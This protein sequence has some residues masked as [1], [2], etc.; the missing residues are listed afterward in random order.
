MQVWLTVSCYR[1]ILM[2]KVAK[3]LFPT[4][5][6]LPHL[7]ETSAGEVL[8]IISFFV[9]L[10]LWGF[11]IVWFIVAVM[12][13]ATSGRFPFNMGWWGFIFPVGMGY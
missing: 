13:V 5:H 6:T 3:K 12:M 8:Y 7:S 2:S 4:T 9:G 1:I 10:I 11:S